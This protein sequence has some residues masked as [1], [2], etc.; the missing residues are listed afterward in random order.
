MVTKRTRRTRTGTG[1]R[2]FSLLLLWGVG[3]VSVNMRHT[4]ARSVSCLSALSTA[5]SSSSPYTNTLPV[6]AVRATTG[7]MISCRVRVPSAQHRYLPRPDRQT[8]T[9]SISLSVITAAGPA[10]RA[11]EHEVRQSK[12]NCRSAHLAWLLA[13]IGRR[14][15][16]TGRMATCHLRSVRVGLSPALQVQETP[17]AC[18]CS[19]RRSAS[20]LSEDCAGSLRQATATS[21][22]VRLL[23][24]E[25]L[26]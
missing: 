8:C 11:T 3:T 13:L 4:L 23:R 9:A 21:S 17:C 6:L 16:V 18:A 7:V 19:V 2:I 5:R 20:S 14:S 25:A 22:I 24:R 12:S 1:T 15:R 26:E 10:G